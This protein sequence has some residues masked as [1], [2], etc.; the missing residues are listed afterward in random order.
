MPQYV[1]SKNARPALKRMGADYLVSAYDTSQR[2]A[3]RVV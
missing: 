1:V 2:R 3:C